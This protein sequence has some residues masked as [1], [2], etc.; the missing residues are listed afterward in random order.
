MIQIYRILFPIL[1]ILLSP[2]YLRRMFRRGGYGKK[3]LYRL[4]YWPK[5]PKKDPRRRRIWIQAVSVGELFSISKMLMELL[6]DPSVEIIL[7]GTTSTGLNLAEQYYGT[8]AL[9]QGPFPLDWLPFSR[10]AWKSI[11]PDLAILVD[12]ELWPEH[13]RQANQRKVP[14]LVINARLSDRSYSRLGSS[15]IAKSLL[16]PSNLL[17]LAA[18]ERQRKRWLELGVQK[19]N[20]QV[21]GNLKIDAIDFKRLASEERET[22]KKEFGFSSESLVLA[23]ISTWPGEE[24]ML[25]EIVQTLRLENLDI[26]LLLIPRHAE[27]S[28]EIKKILDAS[29]LSHHL[30]SSSHLAPPDN[31]VYLADTTGELSRLIQVTDFAFMGKTLPPNRGGQNPIEPIA[32]GI[33]L[34]VGPNHENFQETCSEMFT[35]GAAQ[36]GESSNQVISELIHLAKNLELREKFSQSAKTWIDRQGTPTRF[37]LEF[38]RTILSNR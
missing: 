23:G 16:I 8:R 35:H 4:G 31:L 12:S 11:D 20:L 28:L 19:Q 13:F 30:R 18:S 3:I 9:A 25:L 24:K 15:S 34:V 5:L 33:P 7:S 17:V 1:S 38:I 14:V 2:Y 21:S 10:R 22:L 29:P 32:L 27:R 6:N 37:T 26:R 36:P